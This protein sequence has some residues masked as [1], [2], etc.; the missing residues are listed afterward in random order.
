MGV[1]GTGD[2]ARATGI[3]YRCLDYWVRQGYLKP[4][5]TDQDGRRDRDWQDTEIEVAKLMFRLT[6]AGLIPSKAVKVARLI[7]D[8]P[9]DKTR[10]S[11]RIST[12]VWVV[13]N[14]ESR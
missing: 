3:T 14:T 4:N 13:I 8:N 10:R 9:A 11:V 12:G 5:I 2:V 1:T 6:T 7:V